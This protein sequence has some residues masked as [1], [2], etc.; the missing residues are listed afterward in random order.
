MTGDSPEG[1]YVF[2]II[3]QEDNLLFI[4][5]S[6]GNETIEFGGDFIRNDDI[7]TI[8]NFDVDGEMTNQLGIKGVK[9]IVV[10]YGRQAGV[11][12]IIIEGA[13][14]TTGAN[15]GKITKLVFDV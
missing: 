11:K 3:A 15:P 5:V 6:I 1:K 4:E 8:K 7:L 2:R 14:R 9:D 10:D 12:K 13:P